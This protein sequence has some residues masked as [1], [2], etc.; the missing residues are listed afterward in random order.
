MEFMLLCH[1]LSDLP[2]PLNRKQRQFG[3]RE[4]RVCWPAVVGQACCDGSMV[5]VGQA[6]DEV[7]IGSASNPNELHALPMQRMVG[8]RH[9]HPFHRRFGKG[10]SVL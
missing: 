8:V 2:Q 3:G 4:S 1:P 10:G 5:T 6:N 9:G 7:R